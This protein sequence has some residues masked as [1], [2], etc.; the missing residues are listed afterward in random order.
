MMAVRPTVLAR[1]V[2]WFVGLGLLVAVVM[3]ATHHSQ[4]TAFARPALHAS[5]GL[6]GTLLVIRARD[7]RGVPR[8][9]SMATSQV[10]R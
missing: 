6:G 7:R 9:A 5:V 10:E 3:L 4:E 2:P 8:G 1:W